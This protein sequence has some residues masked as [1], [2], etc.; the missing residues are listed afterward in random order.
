M[1][2]IVKNLPSMKETQV[3]SLGREDPLVKG[4]VTHSSIL[5]WR[6]PWSE[7]LEGCSPRDLKESDMT[8]TN[9][10]P[11]KDIF[12]KQRSIHFC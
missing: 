7:S 1:S 3:W 11:W 12:M 8:E 5:A 4:M 10:G 2:Q 9:P 6:I